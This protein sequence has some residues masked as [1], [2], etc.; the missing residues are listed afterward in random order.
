MG[1]LDNLIISLAIMMI[2]AGLVSVAFRKLKLPVVL[3]YI[4]VG[5]IISPNTFDIGFID[6]ANIK[7]LGEIGV[8]F[9]MFA[10]GLEFSFR[11]IATVGTSAIITASTVMI[12]MIIIGFF[13]GGLLGF[14]E[15]DAIFLGAMLSMSST[16]II[17]KAFEEYGM[18]EEKFASL[19][20]GTMVIEDVGAVFIMIVLSSIAVGKN[21]T[22]MEIGTEIGMLL[23]Y[24]VVWLVI[25]IYLIPTVL[26]K[27]SKFLNDETLLI[28]SLAI[29]FGMVVAAYYT[30]FS[31]ALGAFIGGSILAGTVKGER[32]EKIIRPLRDL[33]GAIFFI[34]VG[35][36]IVPATLLKYIIPI[37]IIAGAT[38]IGQGLLST[39][40]M[41]FSGQS[42]RT[43]IRG[44]SAMV[45]VGEFS[46]I[47]AAL[48]LSLG[49]ISDF[50]Y[51][52]IVSVSIITI[53]C[54]PIFVKNSEKFLEFVNKYL[55][56]GLKAK[57]RKYTSDSRSKV[58]K[59][60]DWTPFLKRYL[61]RTLITSSL[62]VIIYFAILKLFGNG[63][64]PGTGVGVLPEDIRYLWRVVIAIM[65]IIIMTP[66]I[67][68]M[69]PRRNPLLMKLWLKARSNRLPL[70][71]LLVFRSVIA[72][73]ILSL[74]LHKILL[75][76]TW[77][78]VLFGIGLVILITRSDFLK[79]QSIKM[80]ARFVMNL[81]EKVLREHKKTFGGDRSRWMRDKIY[82]IELTAK[83]VKENETLK[84]FHEIKFTR[85]LIAK[86]IR[87]EQHILLPSQEEKIYEGDILEAMGIEEALEAYMVFLEKAE[88]IK[89]PDDSPITMREYME[90]EESM[91][92]PAEKQI[93]CDAI[94]IEKG[95]PLARKSIKNSQFRAHFK[96]VIVGIERKDLAIV[97][98][99]A[100]TIIEPGDIVW[101]VGSEEMTVHLIR[102]GLL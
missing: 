51:P 56:V 42:L 33:F 23:L 95:N 46:F 3:G 30:G 101:V 83:K 10:L 11:R 44:G 76:P 84:S 9:L 50:L 79:G 55:P 25:G 31:S 39:I 19:V 91:K 97:A 88:H 13:I 72:V 58:E 85:I 63:I 35:M 62:L 68:I 89:E 29:C 73:I 64:L 80:Q 12:G 77:L 8:I 67:S 1:H 65:V 52:V 94:A 82:V 14:K 45:Q 16:M 100:A 6:E 27:I 59:D 53:A 57:I 49:V 75:F 34:S 71:V 90:E 21:V 87:G 43:A 69:S 38:I 18:K 7:V 37:L 15:M 2:A 28:I 24:L 61:A 17:M 22:G 81:N 78:T 54:T 74:T 5:I 102:D 93:I 70:M 41:I 86:I 92:L 47:I 60:K 66:I 48:G 98:P 26:K 96:G 32:I 20:L 99:S 4:V 40:G 36:L